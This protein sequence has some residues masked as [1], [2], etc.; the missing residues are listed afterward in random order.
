MLAM[1]YLPARILFTLMPASRAT[2]R[3]APTNTMWRPIGVHFS[4]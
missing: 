3:F 4:T 2:S 1:M